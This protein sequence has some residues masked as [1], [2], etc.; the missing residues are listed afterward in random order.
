M[1]GVAEQPIVTRDFGGL[2]VFWSEVATPD[3]LFE[4]A[5]AKAAEEKYKQVLREVVAYTTV[6]ALPFPALVED[7]AG[8]DAILVAQGETYSEALRRL[9]GMVQYELTATWVEDEGADLA[10]P[11]SGSEYLKRRQQAEARVAATDC[12]LRSVTAEIVIEWRAKQERR[13]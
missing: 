1:T 7:E 5:S 11:I 3:A 2:R 8:I 13:N 10:T 12:K 9:A 6:I 4:G